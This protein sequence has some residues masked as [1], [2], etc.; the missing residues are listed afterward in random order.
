MAHA[1]C[2]LDRQVC[3]QTL[4]ICNTYCFSVFIKFLK[5]KWEYS[6]AVHELILDFK[7]AYDFS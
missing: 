4:R 7:K 6:E 5:K 3:K 1:H 2:M